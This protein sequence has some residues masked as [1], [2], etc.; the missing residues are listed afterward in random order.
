MVNGEKWLAK[1]IQCSLTVIPLENYD[2]KATYDLP[3]KPSP[4]I[5]NNKAV[6]LYP[7][8]GLFE[9]SIVSLG[10]GTEMP[11]QIIGYPQFTT[12][13]FSFQPKPSALSAKPKYVNQICYGLDLRNDAYITYHP[14]QLQL[15]WLKTMFMAFPS[16]TFFDKNFNYH[17]GNAQ[18]KQAILEGKSTENI[19][20]S[21][22]TELTAFKVIRKKYLL[23]KDVEGGNAY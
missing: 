10:R 19:R 23:Y 21:W 14:K 20:Q 18:L 8:L 16:D 15:D 7:T 4:N 11:F 22:Q 9:G 6:L 2:R 13:S 5:P 12:K 3:V 1:G 17:A